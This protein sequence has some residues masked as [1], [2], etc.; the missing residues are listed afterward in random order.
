MRRYYR[1]ED[2]SLYDRQTGRYIDV[3]A[4]RLIGGEYDINHGEYLIPEEDVEE[5]RRAS[6]PRRARSP[7][8]LRTAAPRRAIQSNCLAAGASALLR[9]GCAIAVAVEIGGNP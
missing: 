2:G 7:S 9:Q 5:L 4:E 1:E 8:P 6:M 3:F